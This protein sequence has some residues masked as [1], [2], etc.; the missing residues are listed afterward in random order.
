[1]AAPANLARN[2]EFSLMSLKRLRTEETDS[3]RRHVTQLVAGTFAWL[4]LSG[5]LTYIAYFATYSLPHDWAQGLP[6]DDEGYWLIALRSY[7]VH[8]SLYHN[9]FAQCGPFY[10]EFWSLIY[11][12]S[13]LSIDSDTAHLM[14]LA[15]WVVTSLVFGFAIAMISK[16][17]LLGL[18]GETVCFLLLMSL[19]NEAMEPA[20]LSNLLVAVVLMGIAFFLRGHRRLGAGIVG[21]GASALLLTKVNVGVFVIAGLVFAIM[22]SWPSSRLLITRKMV[23]SLGLMLV[24][25][26]LMADILA[27][28]WVQWLLLLELL[29]IIGFLAI[30]W[31]KRPPVIRAFTSR[32][33]VFGSV[34]G[35]AG[36]VLIAIGVL[37]NG[38]TFTEL[39]RGALLNQRNIARIFQFGLPITPGELAFAGISAGLAVL[40]AVL[41]ASSGT[42]P[43]WLYSGV[44][45]FARLAIGIWILLTVCSEPAYGT[46]ATSAIA[47]CCT[48]IVLPSHV[49]A[50]HVPGQSFLL[51]APLAWVAMLGVDA[52]ESHARH[53]ARVAICA[54]GLVC[55]LEA[56]PTAAS[57]LSWASLSLV[58]V[59]AMCVADGLSI[60]TRRKR[61]HER[62]GR[63]A[64]SVPAGSLILSALLLVFVGGVAYP[65]LSQYRNQ[66]YADPPSRL[67][68]AEKIH[69]PLAVAADFQT[70]TGF[71]REHCSTFEDLPGMN[72]FYF[73]SGEDPPTGLNTTDW[74][75]FLNLEQQ[76]RV[77]A[78][79]LRTPRLCVLENGPLVAFRDQA[80][81]LP[82]TPL[83]RYIEG[84]FVV[85]K[86]VGSYQLLVRKS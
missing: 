52:E 5:F 15:I 78:T 59:G 65:L 54:V 55:C 74:M 1:M 35:I 13:H 40:I 23:A 53:F 21:A 24:P 17:V 42:T 3:R 27:S 60:M 30:A 62:T 46:S 51:A 31:T 16:R 14:T 81:R 71:L 68:G 22:I 12:I 79:L 80:R 44:S 50:V 26:L 84:D 77:L 28:S 4:S 86:D 64:L 20:G 11:S 85:A 33:V 10:Y 32:D 82:Q 57:Q 73:F 58:P 2:S 61:Q 8:G 39:I 37:I 36:A 69:L 72:S 67:T 63:E 38:T 45:G 70:I 29:S 56:F 9:T 25:V 75:R 48:G 76:D 49:L 19:A 34:V 66:Y 83:V 41:S 47:L 18:I 6:Y 43:V 7:H